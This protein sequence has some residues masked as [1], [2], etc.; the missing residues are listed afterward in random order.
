MTDP[1]CWRLVIADMHAR[2]E[3]GIRRYGKPVTPLIEDELDAEDWLQHAYE[4][5]LD[6]AVYLKAEIERRRAKQ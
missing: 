5:A 3:V 6:L 4:E 1:D 2:R